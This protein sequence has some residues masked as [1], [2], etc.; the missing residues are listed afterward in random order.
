MKIKSFILSGFIGGVLDF[1]IGWL[2]YNMLF[3]EYFGIDKQISLGAVF[4]E[5]LSFGFL[6]AFIFVYLSHT[7][8]F[9]NGLRIGATLGLLVGVMSNFSYWGGQDYA[10]WEKFLF[11]VVLYF[12]TGAIVGGGIGIC[13]R[14]AS[15]KIRGAVY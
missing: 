15:P 7:Q 6:I 5:S 11:D 2:F 14:A 13:N 8:T 3:E 4:G 12:V 10:D 1:L 9:S